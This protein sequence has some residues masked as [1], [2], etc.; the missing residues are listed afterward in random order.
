M[1]LA[2]KEGLALINGTQLMTGIAGLALLEAES[3]ARTADVIAAMTVDALLGT[4]VAFDPRIHAARP[5]AGQ[6]ASARNLRRLLAGS[7][8]RE[9]HRD[10]GRVQ[11]IGRAHV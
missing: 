4:D 3:L 10:C 5:H 11:E 9:S 1:T 6:G 8:M 2:A 7:A